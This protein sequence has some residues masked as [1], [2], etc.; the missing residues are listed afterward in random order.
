MTR[1]CTS[2]GKSITRKSKKGLCHGCSCADPAVRA[3]KGQLSPEQRARRAAAARALSADPAIVAK[4]S[5]KGKETFQRPEVRERHYAACMAAQ[6]RMD[7]AVRERQREAGRAF[8]KFN[9]AHTRTAEARAKSGA[10]TRRTRMA[11]CPEAYWPLNAK[12]ARDGIRLDDRKRMIAEQVAA[13]E[14]AKDAA[15]TPFE[16]QLARVA[17]GAKLIEVRPIRR[18]EPDMTLGGVASSYL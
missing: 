13:D 4:R 17:A 18:I 5:A 15:L 2:C 6:E 11:W 8:G 7:P 14:R 10:A 3:K 16:R 1:S 9:L 12:L